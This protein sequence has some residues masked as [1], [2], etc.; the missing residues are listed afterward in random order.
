MQYSGTNS[1]KLYIAPNI[2]S[3]IY[4]V[5]DA[6]GDP[7]DLVYDIC[8]KGVTGNTTFDADGLGMTSEKGYSVAVYMSAINET[9]NQLLPGFLNISFSEVSALSAYS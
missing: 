3:D 5:R 4:V 6:K 8:F 7:N 2:T 1:T 9:A